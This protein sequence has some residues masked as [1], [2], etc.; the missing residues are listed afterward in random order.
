ML[1]MAMDAAGA[2]FDG[3]FLDGE[4]SM[5]ELAR[6]IEHSLGASLK[7]TLDGPAKNRTNDPQFLQQ[8]HNAINQLNL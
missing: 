3:E 8:V 4:K 6:S 7:D 2:G 5:T 1:D